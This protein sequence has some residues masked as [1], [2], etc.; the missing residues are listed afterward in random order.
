MRDLKAIK[1]I[2]ENI[3]QK[4]LG[5]G[6]YLMTQKR[7]ESENPIENQLFEMLEDP[8][9]FEQIDEEE[10]GTS[11]LDSAL[12]SPD[13]GLPQGI[14]LGG[15]SA[16]VAL[17]SFCEEYQDKLIMYIDD[18]LLMMDEWDPL[19]IMKMSGYLSESG[20]TISPNKSGY[21]KRNGI[22]L[23][24]IKFLGLVYD[25]NS[26]LIRA[27]TRKGSKIALP[28]L[29]KLK[30]KLEEM[31]YHNIRGDTMTNWWIANRL[32]LTDFMLAYMFNRGKIA[33]TE[34]TT[35]RKN[36]REHSESFLKLVERLRSDLDRTNSTSKMVPILKRMHEKRQLWSINMKQKWKFHEW[37]ESIVASNPS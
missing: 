34:E 31:G 19:I 11:W 27:N 15:F 4:P 35:L 28:D 23:K 1:W 30:I 29:E 6:L 18:G 2:K 3:S 7:K 36:R 8:T 13:R 17:K 14:A 10:E 32:N 24:P 12:P 5:H 37:L 20:I 25:G 22:W 16:C 21:I 26:G 9:S 33:T